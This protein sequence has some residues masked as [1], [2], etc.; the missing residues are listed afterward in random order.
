MEGG[1]GRA[2]RVFERLERGEQAS[3]GG[4]VAAEQVLARRA[5]RDQADAQVGQRDERERLDQRLQRPLE[6]A[7]GGERARER[8]EQREPATGVDVDGA[9]RGETGGAGR[10]ETDGAGQAGG[11]EAGG[12]GCI[13]GR[14]E[15]PQGGLEPARGDGRCAGG[16]LVAGLLEHRGGGLVADAGR[17]LHV[18]RSRGQRAR[19]VGQRR[20]RARVR[21]EP[22]RLAGAVVDRAADQGV[23]EAVAARDLGGAGEVGGQQLV[24]RRQR[25]ALVH[26][27]RRGGEVQVERL[28][29]HRGAPPEP[30][31]ALRQPADLLPHG[32]GHRGR[33]AHLIRARHGG[34]HHGRPRQLF[35]VERV[36]A[37][38]AIE[39]RLRDAQQRVGLRLAQRPEPDLAH[40]PVA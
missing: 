8:D 39:R 30:P 10:G 35:E 21:L 22:P 18:M 15:Q 19:P 37:A 9:G 3:V 38:L 1:G 12:T 33:D 20:R 23:A 29:R 40:E 27:G 14:A 16:G 31:G 11:H 24:D 34:G 2:A 6:A 25:R 5:R 26:P 32:G 4:G 28:A 7:G 17:A 13:D 36:P